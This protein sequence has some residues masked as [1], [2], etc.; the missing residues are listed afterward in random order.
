MTSRAPSGSTVT[1]VAEL[2]P[3]GRAGPKKAPR[4]GQLLGYH[5]PG[6]D[7]RADPADRWVTSHRSTGWRAGARLP[8][9]RYD[10][11]RNTALAG[12]DNHVEE[13]G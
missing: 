3:L 10:K 12:R 2:L 11:D 6:P 5:R 7:R 8:A 13:V 1:L 4:H 9:S